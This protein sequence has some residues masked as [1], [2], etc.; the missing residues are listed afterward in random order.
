METADCVFERRIVW[1]ENGGWLFQPGILEDHPDYAYAGHKVKKFGMKPLPVEGIAMDSSHSHR[2]PLWLTSLADAHPEGSTKRAFYERLKK[3]LEIQLFNKVI[4]PPTE[5]FQAW[6]MTNYMDGYNGIYRWNY[7]TQGMNNGYGPYEL[8]GTLLLGW[9]S[10]LSSSR[11]QN[12]Y[13]DL[14]RNFPL[15]EEVIKTYTGP[16]TTRE[17]H[18]LVKLPEAYKNGMIEII[19][20]LAS[21]IS[22]NVQ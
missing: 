12:V 5:E 4:I 21:K 18:P 11:I 7:V 16:N 19:V 17:R 1:Q 9:W 20:R 15:P 2:F 13:N 3:E 14:A 8:S 10:F 22:V 6:R